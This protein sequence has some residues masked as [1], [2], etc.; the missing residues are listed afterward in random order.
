MGRD[1]FRGSGAAPSSV[2]ERRVGG[3]TIGRRHGGRVRGM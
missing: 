1:L 2:A 3:L